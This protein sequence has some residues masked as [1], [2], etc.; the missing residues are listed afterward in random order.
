MALPRSAALTRAWVY[1]V[2]RIMQAQSW[3]KPRRGV[4][5]VG[6]AVSALNPC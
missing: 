5:K 4:A 6:R 1:R 2:F 3:R